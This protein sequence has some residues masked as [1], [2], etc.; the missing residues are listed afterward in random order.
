[1]RLFAHTERTKKVVVLLRYIFAH[2]K[3]SLSL[4]KCLRNNETRIET[5]LVVM[6]MPTNR[7][8]NSNHDKTTSNFMIEEVASAAALAV[9]RIS[10]G[11]ALQG[12]NFQKWY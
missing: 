6:M 3:V 12:D 7:Y 1:M 9:G 2:H 4:H 5:E 10:W 8:K 11:T